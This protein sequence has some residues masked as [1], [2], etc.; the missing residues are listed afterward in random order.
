MALI[1]ATTTGGDE[2]VESGDPSIQP[3]FF[4]DAEDGILRLD[5]SPA[6]M[7]ANPTATA[8]SDVPGSMPASAASSNSL[9]V[10]LDSA[11]TAEMR[12][13]FHAG[14][15][16]F[17]KKNDAAAWEDFDKA[18]K[19]VPNQAEV[20]ICKALVL[21]RQGKI[22]EAAAA[23]DRA[24]EIMPENVPMRAMRAGFRLDQKEYAKARQD[25][26]TAMQMR[27]GDEGL[28]FNLVLTYLMEKNQ[29][30][31]R[32]EVDQFKVPSDTAA[33]Y[34]ASS[35]VAYSAGQIK[36]SIDWISSGYRIFGVER[37]T[38]FYAA[39]QRAGLI[40]VLD[41]PYYPTLTLGGVKK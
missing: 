24:V 25:L 35:A 9:A 2:S 32:A 36:E 18:D 40:K 3:R 15:L 21:N 27:P 17:T 30:A 10:Q 1:A 12:R 22:A 34:F 20:Q 41:D 23:Y 19:L 13:L 5:K 8:S 4:E 16:A 33:Y 28:R 31:A 38:P 6:V 14:M 37:C 26:A 29:A 11:V 7:P 39:L